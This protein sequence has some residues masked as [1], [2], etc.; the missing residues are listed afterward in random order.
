MYFGAWM[1]FG[2]Q[3]DFFSSQGRLIGLCMLFKRSIT[4]IYSEVYVSIGDCMPVTQDNITRHKKNRQ[5][6]IHGTYISR[7]N[8]KMGYIPSFSTLPIRTCA[9]DVPCK[10]DCYAVKLAKIRPTVR[11]TWEA[12]TDAVIDGRY[13]DI[14]ADICAYLDAH[15][16]TAAFRWNVSGDI[17]GPEFLAMMIQLARAYPTVAFMAFTKKYGL[18]PIDRDAVPDNLRLVLSAW[19]SYRPADVL[20]KQYPVAYFDD[21]SAECGIPSDAFHCGGNCERCLKCFKMGPGSSVYFTKH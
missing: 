11:A 13:D 10:K 7:G 18:V 2:E 1:Y 4:F 21:G 8:E 9:C 19:K 15:P 6:G 5:W 14:Y 20:A 17:Y 12:N 16:M 3:E